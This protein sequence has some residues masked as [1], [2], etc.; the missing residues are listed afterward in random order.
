MGDKFIYLFVFFCTFFFPPSFLLGVEGSNVRQ[1][2][3]R[4]K[5]ERSRA[6]GPSHPNG[7]T[8]TVFGSSGF[9]LR[10]VS[11][12]DILNLTCICRCLS[13]SQCSSPLLNKAVVHS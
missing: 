10:P 2:L 5:L 3:D 1:G 11:Y 9:R 6:N 8:Q 13:L 4:G 7:E 12:T